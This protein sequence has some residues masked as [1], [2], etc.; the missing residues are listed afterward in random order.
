[1]EQS[2]EF[3]MLTLQSQGLSESLR[4]NGEASS[5][6]HGRLTVQQKRG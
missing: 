5:V 2:L 1:M 6:E 4:T 3:Y